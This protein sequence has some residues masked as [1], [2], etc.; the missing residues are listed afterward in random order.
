[1]RKENWEED[2]RKD[3]QGA[4]KVC[5]SIASSSMIFLSIE[6]VSARRWK[7]KRERTNKISGGSRK[8]RHHARFIL[9]RYS[10]VG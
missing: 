5:F 1:V 6:G 8:Q 2:T 7:F 3:R 9:A 4:P 10:T